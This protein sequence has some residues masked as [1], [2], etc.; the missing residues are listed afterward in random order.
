MGFQP[1]RFGVFVAI[2]EATIFTGAGLLLLS[3]ALARKFDQA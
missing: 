2:I 3:G 1:A